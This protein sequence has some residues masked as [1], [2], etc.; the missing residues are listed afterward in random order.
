M[1]TEAV[2]Y[3][4]NTG[5]TRQY[6]QLLGER[7]GLPVYSLEEAQRALPSGSSVL[8]LG[9]LMAGTVK[10]YGKAAKRFCI[11]A[12]CAVG[13]G[14]AGSQL[15]EVRKS[16]ALPD[17]LPLFTLQGGFDSSRLRG[18][19]KLM[20]N[21]MA[22]TL[23]KQLEQKP[24]RTAEESDMLDLLRNGGSRVRAEALDGVLNWYEEVC[25]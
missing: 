25:A 6:A 1:K 5:Y 9:W 23:G 8:Y 2:V 13:M 3:T 12:V 11:Q 14:A 10:G 18:V 19:Y 17:T 20:M 16:N 4:S 7:T 22:K 24:D 15:K 21:V